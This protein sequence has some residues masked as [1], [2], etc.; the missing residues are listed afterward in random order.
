MVDGGSACF[1]L[2]AS[3]FIGRG[4]SLEIVSSIFLF[5]ARLVILGRDVVLPVGPRVGLIDVF[6]SLNWL[7]LCELSYISILF[8]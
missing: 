1:C 8:I 2:A 3:S 4:V 6:W 7:V 5:G